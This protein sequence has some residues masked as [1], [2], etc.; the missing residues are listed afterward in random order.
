M[1][2][3]KADKIAPQI[4]LI[5]PS[6]VDLINFQKML[7]RILDA[8]EIACFR[9]ALS[10]RDEDYVAHIADN[11]RPICHDRDVAMIIET[12]SALVEP[13]G[14]DGV[15]LCHDLR[16]LATIRKKMSKDLILGAGCGASRHE[17]LGAGEK[18]ADYVSFGPLSYTRLGAMPALA[19]YDLFAW[20]SEMVEIP[21]IAEGHVSPA[22][23]E[24]MADVIDF[25]GI[26]E[27][28]WTSENP[29]DELHRIIEPLQLC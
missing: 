8:I 29:V 6:E 15:H 12:H 21:V 14:L 1:A 9:L 20:W 27:E 3:N 22:L 28:I 5:S 2:N 24:K 10:S 4:Y 26:G 17:G 11:L 18:G 7:A 19:D 13:L 16:P 23:V 25:L